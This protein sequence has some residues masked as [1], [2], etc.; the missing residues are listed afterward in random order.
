MVMYMK[1]IVHIFLAAVVSHSAMISAAQPEKI[2][3][4]DEHV[5]AVFNKLGVVTPEPN[6][7]EAQYVAYAEA[8]ELFGHARYVLSRQNNNITI[9]EQEYLERY[10]NDV[11][12]GSYTI[13]YETYKNCCK[14][15]FFN[16]LCVKQS[17]C[18]GNNLCVKNLALCQLC[19][20]E[21]DPTLVTAQNARIASLTTS[22][23]TGTNAFI[24]NLSGIQ[25]INGLAITGL[26]VPAITGGTGIT[27]ITGNTGPQGA[28]GLTGVP[29]AQ[30]PQGVAFVQEDY[31]AANKTGTQT[32]GSSS[33]TVV[34]YD[35]F[36][37]NDGWT[38]SDFQ[39]FTIP[40]TGLYRI[41]YS[42]TF[43]STVNLAL[44]FVAT[45]NSFAIFPSQFVVSDNT[46]NQPRTLSISFL[47]QITQANSS[48]GV[49][50]NNGSASSATIA[51]LPVVASISATKL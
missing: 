43:T 20:N 1:R 16:R 4:L 49:R 13:D 32:I 9:D 7:R 42:I 39:S 22:Y 8:D 14:P 25:T 34:Q 51:G 29:G 35:A 21:I 30:G 10:Y 28:Q 2:V 18:I 47:A 31:F 48:L 23:L 38:T 50:I 6:T 12:N 11:Q 24:T 46:P 3:V 40:T 19:S 36:E 17:A 33:N 26:L 27:G 37:L 15:K 44:V 5:I 41:T 45:L